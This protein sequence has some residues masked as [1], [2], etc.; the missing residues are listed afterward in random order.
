MTIIGASA[1]CVP[2]EQC[3]HWIEILIRDEHNQPFS[4]VK[5]TLIDGC[6]KEHSITVGEAPILLTSLAAGRVSIQLDA[7]TWQQETEK[8]L[9]FEGK[10]SPVDQ[11]LAQNPQGY[12]AATRTRHNLTLG[13]MLTLDESETVLPRHKANLLGTPKLVSDNSHLVVIQ[14]CRF[15][16]LRLGVFFDGTAN[17]T[18]SAKWGKQKLDAYYNQW[19]ASYDA[20]KTIAQKHGKS[21]VDLPVTELMDSCFEFAGLEG[22]AANELT[23]I[24]KLFDLYLSDVFNEDNTVFQHAQYITGIGTGNST[25]IGPAEEDDTGY[26]MGIGDYGVAA[27]VETAVEQICRELKEMVQ[28]IERTHSEVDGFNKLEFDVFG[29]SRGAAAA[30]HFINTVLDGIVGFFAQSF[31]DECRKLELSLSKGFDWDDNEFSE[32]MFAGLFDT[33]AAIANWKKQDLSP[34]DNNNAPIRLWLD[35]FRV[36]KVVHLTANNTTEYRKNFSSNKVNSASNFV[37]LSLPGA[38]S[39]IGGGYHSRMSFAQKDYL[40][41]LLENKQIMEKNESLRKYLFLTDDRL[42]K[43]LIDKL[44]EAHNA[45]IDH[46]WL[47]SDYKYTPIIKQGNLASMRLLYRKCTEGDLSRLYLRVMYGLAVHSGVPIDDEQDNKNIWLS[48]DIKTSMYY[49]VPK[50]L[51]NQV[52]KDFYPFGK[53]SNHIL[54]LAKLGEIGSL[55]NELSS[56]R[57]LK[58]FNELGLIHHSSDGSVLYGVIYPMEAHQID[59]QYQR[60]AY[61]CEKDNIIDYSTHIGMQRPELS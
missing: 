16:T 60:E 11:W 37:E 39:D 1:H 27:K 24:Q 7:E 47:E 61:E 53:F 8:R 9:P 15:I 46:G 25:V 21:A 38:H 57:R 23:N 41:P 13:D 5:G 51:T 48:D 42:N 22:S 29:F 56:N 4:N 55:K 45:E 52:T 32:I 34:H 33:V 35:P 59:G 50:Y 44:E 54:N 2:C 3:S 20:S 26:G 30:R 49:S 18:Y 6:G 58:I 31:G 14:G 12:E 43:I 40:L 28:I 17:N 36:K 10:E 19:K